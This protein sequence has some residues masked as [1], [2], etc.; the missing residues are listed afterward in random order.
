MLCGKLLPPLRL[1]PA[2][3]GRREA[4]EREDFF[5][6]LVNALWEVLCRPGA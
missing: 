3:G 4:G 2:G 6:D 1:K 5:G